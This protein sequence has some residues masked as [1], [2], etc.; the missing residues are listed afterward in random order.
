MAI[1]EFTALTGLEVEQVW[2]WKSYLRLVF[3]LGAP[4]QVC[5]FVDLTDFQYVDAA[6]RAW[7]VRVEDDPLTA[8]PVLGLLDHRVA[9]ARVR[10][11]ELTLT[12]DNGANIACPPQASYEAWAVCLPDARWD[13]PPGASETDWPHP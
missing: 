2:V 6:S 11:W 1:G 12:F 8:G 9:A 5:V 10:N 7:D 3:D 13:C 4:G